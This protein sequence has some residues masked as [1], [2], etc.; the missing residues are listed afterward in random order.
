MSTENHFQH[1]GLAESFEIDLK[2]LGKAYRDK[3][4][5]V[6][7]DRF[8]HEPANIQRQAVQETAL[9]TERYQTLKSA[10]KRGSYLLH[11]NDIDFDLSR[12]TVDDMDMLIEQLSFREQ[13]SEIKENSDHDK[14]MDFQDS[15]HQKQASL[16]Q[17]IAELF[18]QDLQANSEQIKA[19][20][21]ELQFF[22]KL[23]YE[24]EQ[25]EEH[26]LMD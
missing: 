19:K 10:V 16:Q 18:A 12:H 5:A 20:L 1:F 23:N 13:L 2:A 11:I 21:C 3:Q 17:D 22:D 26:L 25:V 9:N 7:P 15:V 4:Q 8:A 6:H 24:C 14:L